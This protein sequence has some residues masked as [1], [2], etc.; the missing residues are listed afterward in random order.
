MVG[1][2]AVVG[3]IVL[4][5]FSGIA[6]GR[7]HWRGITQGSA[8]SGL[9]WVALIQVSFAYSGW[10]AAS[11]LAGEVKEL[12]LLDVSPLTLGIETLGS[13]MTPLIE[14]NTTIPT[15]K[16]QVFS[17]AADGQ[18]SVEEMARAAKAR[19]RS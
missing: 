7:G 18:T 16:S 13:I 12:V 8:G 14:R 10:N 19:G 6:T 5:V 4:F 2:G 15:S 1:E 9:W 3:A 11:Y 17:T